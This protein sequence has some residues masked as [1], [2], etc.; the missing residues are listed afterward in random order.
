LLLRQ[1][2]SDATAAGYKRMTLETA[3]FMHHAHKLYRSHGFKVREPYRKQ[4]TKLDEI[5]I[6]MEAALASPPRC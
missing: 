1:V 5:T 6:S 3:T 4:S 2:L